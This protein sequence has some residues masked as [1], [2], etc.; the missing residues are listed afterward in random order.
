ME[1][2]MRAAQTFMLRHLDGIIVLGLAVG[3][4]DC[5]Y[6]RVPFHVLQQWTGSIGLLMMLGFLTAANDKKP[7]TLI[8]KALM[9]IAG[10]SMI[11]LGITE[12]WFG[13]HHLLSG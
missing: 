6:N 13:T 1:T 7:K 3:V 2:T 5:L 4:I 11:G 10:F 12:I 9:I 8:S